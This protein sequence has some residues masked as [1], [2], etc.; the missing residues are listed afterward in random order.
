MHLQDHSLS[1]DLMLGNIY[2][3]DLALQKV[4][5]ELFCSETIN[6]RLKLASLTIQTGD[7]GVKLYL[8]KL[9]GRTRVL[10]LES[11]TLSL[12]DRAKIVYNDQNRLP[13]W[14]VNKLFLRNQSKIDL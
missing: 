12:T 4:Q 13:N 10:N 11:T 14:T 5:L 6:N 1:V 8:N 2:P 7:V 3:D 9:L